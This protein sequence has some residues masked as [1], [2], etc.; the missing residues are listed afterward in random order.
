MSVEFPLEIV[1]KLMAILVPLGKN[2]KKKFTTPR[3]LV[4]VHSV[5]YIFPL[6]QSATER[7]NK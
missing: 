5:Y 4:S 3:T 7:I 2:G 6:L 1:G